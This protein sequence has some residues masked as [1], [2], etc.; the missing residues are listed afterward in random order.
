MNLVA[1]LSCSMAITCAMVCALIL[2]FPWKIA[3][4]NIRRIGEM[5]KLFT[6]AGVIALTAFISP[7]RADRARVR[8]LVAPEDF[9]EI[10]CPAQAG[11]QLV[12]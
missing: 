4:E 1:E 12:E 9:I 11:I 8:S 5:A 6:E 10:Y 3:W 7:Y 2:A